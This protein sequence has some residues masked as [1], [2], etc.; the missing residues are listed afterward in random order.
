MVMPFGDR[1]GAKNGMSATPLALNPREKP[2]SPLRQ[3][4][5]RVPV[6]R[7]AGV[8]GQRGWP[9]SR[10]WRPREWWWG[11]ARPQSLN[12]KPYTSNSNPYTLN[13]ETGGTG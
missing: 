4:S 12:F 11:T 7:F 13:P 1:R 5:L 8:Q 3:G 10:S 6:G 9:S 2:Q